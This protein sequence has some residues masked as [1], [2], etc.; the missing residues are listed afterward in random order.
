M[1]IF[2]DHNKSMGKRTLLSPIKES[3]ATAEPGYMRE[4]GKA[5]QYDYRITSKTSMK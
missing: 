4:K 1:P 5:R 3:T 2:I